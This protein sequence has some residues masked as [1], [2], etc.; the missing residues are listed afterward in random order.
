MRLVPVANLSLFLSDLK[1]RLEASYG[2]VKNEI[3]SNGTVCF[4]CLRDLDDD[5]D[6]NVEFLKTTNNLKEEIICS[7]C[8]TGW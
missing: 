4:K 2:I 3:T 1:Y 7:L 5:L 8:L 6:G